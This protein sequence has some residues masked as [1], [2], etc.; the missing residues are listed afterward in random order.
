MKLV[1][2]EYPQAPSTGAFNR[3]FDLGMPAMG[4]LGELFD[5]FWGPELGAHQPAVDLYE[6]DQNFFARLEL[7]GVKKDAINLELENAVL[8]FSGS[9]SQETK[10]AKSAYSFQ[11]SISVPDGVVLDKIKASY[12]DGILTV[13]MPKEESCKARHITVK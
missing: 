10:E 2:Y 13:T 9:Y 1:R 3:L 8:T 7:P 5:D 6:D 11:R 12:E 4:R